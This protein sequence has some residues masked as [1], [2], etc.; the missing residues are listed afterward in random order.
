MF[1][2]RKREGG[3]AEFMLPQHY[4]CSS[5]DVM[6]TFTLTQ[7]HIRAFSQNG[8]F[9]R[10]TRTC[11]LLTFLRQITVPAVPQLVVA[12][13]YLNASERN[14]RRL[15]LPTWTAGCWKN[16]RQISGYWSN[17]IPRHTR[18]HAVDV[19]CER[20]VFLIM[21]RPEAFPDKLRALDFRVVVVVWSE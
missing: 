19:V 20:A 13:G 21:C 14:I 4:F 2:G 1:V 17:W 5:Y 18:R 16:A 8:Y 6:K 10:I 9:H 12:G 7:Q 3:I 15:L 11:G